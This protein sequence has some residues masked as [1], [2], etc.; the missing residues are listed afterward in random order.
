MLQRRTTR[1]PL[2]SQVPALLPLPLRGSGASS[3]SSD[4]S[5]INGSQHIQER[6]SASRSPARP[7]GLNSQPK[8]FSRLLQPEVYHSLTQIDTASPFLHPSRQPTVNSSIEAL[9]ST[10]H[11]RTAAILAAQRLTSSVNAEDHQLIFELFYIRVACLT[12]IG[13]TS[14]AAQEIK[15]LDD[16]NSSIYRDEDQNHLVPWELRV[17]AIRLQA[18]GLND[19]RKGVVGYYELAKDARSEVSRMEAES[20]DDRKVHEVQL[21]RARLADLGVRVANSLVDIGELD[22]ASQFLAD[23]K[24]DDDPQLNVT[25]ALLWLR[26]GDVD[27]ARECMESLERNA[28]QA[29]CT[30]ATGDYSAAVEQ[31]TALHEEYANDEM[32][33]QNLA[34]CLLYAGNMDQV[35]TLQSCNKYLTDQYAGPGMFANI[36]IYEQNL[37]DSNFQPC[38]HLRTV[39]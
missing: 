31:W 20:F 18:I 30:M 33:M 11:F 17:L 27:A 35:C 4:S 8:D 10:G 6:H 7:P 29:L 24:R 37:S 13:L 23:M 21:W 36:T 5:G 16:L 2:D 3:P 19:V 1:G 38:H 15:C 12:L 28:I 26:V 39:Y 14:L 34:V 9:L 25:R 22:A 32:I